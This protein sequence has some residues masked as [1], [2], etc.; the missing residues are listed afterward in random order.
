[1]VDI[2]DSNSPEKSDAMMA[3]TKLKNF[4][5]VSSASKIQTQGDLCKDKDQSTQALRVQGREACCED[6]RQTKK[7]LQNLTSNNVRDLASNTPF[8]APQAPQ[9]RRFCFRQFRLCSLESRNSGQANQKSRPQSVRA[10]AAHM[11]QVE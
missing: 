6:S 5:L 2:K 9:F 4:K 3:S 8:R 7:Q 1:M 10:L 11:R